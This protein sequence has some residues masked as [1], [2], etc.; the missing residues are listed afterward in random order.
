MKLSM[1]LVTLVALTESVEA[2]NPVCA[3]PAPSCA[4]LNKKAAASCSSL[5][6]KSQAFAQLLPSTHCSVISN[7]FPLFS[8]VQAC[9]RDLQNPKG[10]YQDYQAS[11]RRYY[12]QACQGHHHYQDHFNYFNHTVDVSLKD[13]HHSMETIVTIIQRH[14]I[15]Q[16]ILQSL[17]INRYFHLGFQ[18]RNF[19]SSNCYSDHPFNQGRHFSFVSLTPIITFYSSTNYLL[20]LSSRHHSLQVIRTLVVQPPRTN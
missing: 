12:N 14:T 8:Q 20:G 4:K 7:V 1:L 19:D 2:A 13:L 5:I 18:E 15:S 9:F 16:H 10:H 6:G 11:S 17:Y 3:A